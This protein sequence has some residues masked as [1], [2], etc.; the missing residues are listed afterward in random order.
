ME[1]RSERWKSANDHGE[2]VYDPNTGKW[3]GVDYGRWE[4]NDN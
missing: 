3:R 1:K 2:I 4:C